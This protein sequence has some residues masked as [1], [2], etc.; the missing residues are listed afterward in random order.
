VTSPPVS[1]VIPVRDGARYL[2]EAVDSVRA[3]TVGEVELIVVD[4]GSEDATPEL[5]R[6][7]DP[8]VRHVRQERLG[9]AAAVNRGVELA[10]G[11]LL[12]FLDAD[13]LWTPRKTELQLA[14]LAAD[15]GL[16]MVFG[17]VRQ[18]HSPELSSEERAAIACSADPL[19]GLSKGTM[20]IRRESL[21]RVGR[22][23]T[24]WRLG[25]FV[26]WHARATEAGL[27]A[28]MLGD[29]VMLRRLHATNNTREAAAAH[30]DYVRI[31]RAALH[32]RR[33]A[34]RRSSS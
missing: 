5:L 6:A 18:F 21:E 1:V 8:P 11:E 27:E 28:T 34:G 23:A 10:R 12:A 26:D 24:E 7:L 20:L 19:P 17:H 14:A 22:F 32:R 15:A 30:V 33:S 3:Q 9:V 2:R 25:D 31:A 16:D 29:V 4:D 13:D